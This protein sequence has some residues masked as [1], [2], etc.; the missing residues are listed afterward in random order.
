MAHALTIGLTG[1]I[2]SGKSTVQEMFVELGVPVLDADQVARD[3]VAPGSETLQEIARTFGAQMLL[4]DGSLDRRRMRE[5][6]FADD[7][8]RQRLEGITHPEIRQR[9]Q[10]W[11]DRQTAP[12]CIL[13]VAILVE[14]GM[15]SLVD[16]VLVVDVPE[17]VQEQRLQ[18]R[19]NVDQVLARRMLAAQASRSERLAAANDILVNVI[20]L[21]QLRGCVRRL[22]EHYLQ[23][24]RDSDPD[25]PG[26]RLP[27]SETSFTM[28]F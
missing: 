7:A 23:L 6:V 9:M 20:P 2:A 12:Y 3:V 11:R 17:A 8:A 16:R 5:H 25:G 18:T 26:L 13:S 21:A 14:G 24:A 15:R 19:D 4:A 22:H 1:G 27:E 28:A 10:A